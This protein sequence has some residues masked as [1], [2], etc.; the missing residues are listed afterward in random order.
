MG[1]KDRLRNGVFQ[2]MV[3]DGIAEP[4]AS[5][6]SFADY[7]G[8]SGGPTHVR[9]IVQPKEAGRVIESVLNRS[10]AGLDDAMLELQ[11]RDAAAR[12]RSERI[13]Q[14]IFGLS[15][16]GLLTSEFGLEVARVGAPR[17]AQDTPGDAVRPA[18]AEN[19]PPEYVEQVLAAMRPLLSEGFTVE[20]AAPDVH[21]YPDVDLS[22]LTIVARGTD[23]PSVYVGQSEDDTIWYEDGGVPLFY[24]ADADPR[25]VA[26]GL[27]VHVADQWY[28]EGN[29]ARGSS[30]GIRQRL[31]LL[32]ARA[33][34]MMEAACDRTSALTDDDDYRLFGFGRG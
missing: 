16:E 24:G 8:P 15:V 30:D 18:I 2:R 21:P 33:E 23:A 26:A 10:G 25:I 22:W 34:A 28:R 3:A 20:R 14:Q 4:V 13:S 17:S 11:D 27:A 32:R 1:L 6:A 29:P 12:S 5:L 9:P 31:V 7:P 19:E